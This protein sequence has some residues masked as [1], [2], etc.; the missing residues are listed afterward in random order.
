MV[1]ELDVSRITLRL[2]EKAQKGDVK[3]DQ[4]HAKLT[5]STLDVLKQGLVGFSP[6]FPNLSLC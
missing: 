6:W 4:I 3:E 2:R 1:R 5:G